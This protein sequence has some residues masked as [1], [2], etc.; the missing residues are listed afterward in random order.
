M[1]HLSG[2]EAA[3]PGQGRSAVSRAAA[4]ADGGLSS[5][6][7]AARLAR[8]GPNELPRARRTPLWR[9][10]ADQVR[11][12]LVMVLLVAAV[13][14]LVTG[15]W[16]DAGV[17]LFV[18]VVN[19][20]VGVAQEVKAGQAIAA[21]SEMTAPEAR[22][23]RDGGQVI[24]PAADVVAGDVLV[25]AEGDIVPADAAVVEAAAL[26]VDESA[27]T[28]ESVPVEKAAADAGEQGDAVSAGTTVVRGRGRAVVTATGAASAM[29]RI[30]ALMGGRHGLTPLQR[31]LAGVGRVLAIAA[32]ALS[33]IVLVTGLARGQGAE[34]MVITA[35][36]LVVA[37][38]P[39]SLPAVVTLALALGARRMSARNA[40][41]RR[42]P[43]VETLGSV[44]VLG[45]DKTGTLTQGDMVVRRLWTPDGG[46]AEV[47][48]TGYAP[49][50][51]LARC[52][53]RLDPGQ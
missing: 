40:L 33:V 8:F 22:V 34:L 52:G 39:E 21:L 3:A 36:S 47:S 24:I 30:A 50:G 10:I 7:A 5:A 1:S 45:T 35:I 31:R 15:D 42:L 20:A 48:G 28:G 13:L 43:A 14:T 18:V 2:P 41:I 53:R 49:D 46:D 32:V 16:T 29:G 6:E 12:P 27:L 44:T 19:T 25:L 4:A 51:Q 9:M 23:L 11:D 17:I 26:L 38:V 37:A